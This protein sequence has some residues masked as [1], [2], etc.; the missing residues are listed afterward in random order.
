MPGLNCSPFP[1]LETD[2]LTLRRLELFDATDIYK[3]RLH[4]EVNKYLEGF[5]HASIEETQVFI[6]RIHKALEN[7]ESIFWVIEL[8]NERTFVGTICLWNF[9]SD[10][11][12]AETGYVLHPDYQGRGYMNESL[13]SVIAY[14]FEEAGLKIIEAYTHKDNERSIKLLLKNGFNLD[15]DRELEEGSNEIVFVL[16]EEDWRQL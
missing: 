3:L 2:R 8:K 16:L 14:G 1:V 10:G 11:L 9:S 6:D 5:A 13:A 7:N 15:A 12:K 4:P